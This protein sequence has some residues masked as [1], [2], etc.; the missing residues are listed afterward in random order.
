VWWGYYS[1]AQF[2]SPYS[3]PYNEV[4]PVDY[5]RRE[6]GSLD[7]VWQEI[8]RI[9]E[10]NRKTSR[11]IGQDLYHLVPLFTDPNLIIEDWHLEVINE[12]NITQNFNVSLGVLDDVPNDRLNCFSV[13]LREYNAIKEIESKKNGN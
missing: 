13:I 8:D 12:Y 2:V 6:Y 7:D 9:V 10:V 3:L 5:V 4:S 11:T 1:S